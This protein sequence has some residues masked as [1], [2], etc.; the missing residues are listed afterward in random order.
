MPGN[1]IVARALQLA[2]K[3]N[4]G[5]DMLRALVVEGFFDVPVPS[6]E[7]VRR[8]AEKFSQRWSSR[9]V[10]PFMLPLVRG[11]VIHAVKPGKGA[12]TFWVSTAV[13][14][15]EA[16]RILAKGRK[17][18]ELEQELFSADL[19]KKLGKAFTP[20]LAELDLVF[21]RCGNSTAFLLRKTLEKLLVI[22]F[23]KVNKAPL[24][25]DAR[26]PGGLIGLE[27]L[28]ELAVRERVDGAPIL[29]GKTGA[30][31]RGVKFLGDTAAHNP[32]VNV[33]MPEIIP[34][35]PYI[36]MAYKELATHL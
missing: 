6:S 21:G 1:E 28:I 33:E 35:M 36:V 18:I 16:L 29:S 31:I 11:G 5:A 32:L 23:R 34:Q 10:Q 14:R 30:A 8:I 9:E 7:V 20:E 22:V 4:S 26:K 12:G 25:E 19:V 24:I 17:L 27:A 3:P 13:A 2:L 15:A